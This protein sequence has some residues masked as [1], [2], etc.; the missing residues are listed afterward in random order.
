MF[1][2]PCDR[3]N[4]VFRSLDKHVKVSNSSVALVFVE[5][6]VAELDRSEKLFWSGL[7][8]KRIFNI[9]NGVFDFQRSV[10]R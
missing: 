7:V 5:K 2:L 6:T 8:R 10:R 3:E 4:K 9:S 1:F